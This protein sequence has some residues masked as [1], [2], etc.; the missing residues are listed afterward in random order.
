MFIGEALALAIY[1]FKKRRD[2]ETYQMRMLEAKSEG[3]EI[4]MNKLMFAIPAACDAINSTLS[5]IALNF[6]TGSVWQMFRGGA[7][8]A[9]FVLSIFMLKMKVKINHIVGSLMAL[10][11]IIIVGGSGLIFSEN[12]TSSGTPVR[13]P[14]NSGSTNCGVHADGHLPYR[15]WLHHDF[16]IEVD[17]EV[18]HRSFTDG[19]L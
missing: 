18:S 15:H 17:D 14:L 13:L 19:G 5:Y 16:R 9:T 10:I 11:G 8:L 3:K 12:S 1:F 2:P 4:K 7:I 6:I